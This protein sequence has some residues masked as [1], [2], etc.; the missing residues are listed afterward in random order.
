M[1]FLPASNDEKWIK[2]IPTTDSPL[3]HKKEYASWILKHTY[4][5]TNLPSDRNAYM[6][7]LLESHPKYAE[8]LVDFTYLQ[9]VR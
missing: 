2:P 6:F 7:M 9:I 4:L 1:K 8:K 5:G 3:T